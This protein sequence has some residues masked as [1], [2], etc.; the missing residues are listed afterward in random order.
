M[1]HGNLV[2]AANHNL[3]AV[4]IAEIA[5]VWFVYARVQQRRG[6]PGPR[7]SMSP[8]VTIAIGAVVVAFWVLRNLPMQPFQWLN[9]AA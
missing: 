5:I 8:A 9:S 3:L 7:F 6:R 2:Q 4:V 1:L